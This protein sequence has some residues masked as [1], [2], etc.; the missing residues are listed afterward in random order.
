MP[1]SGEEAL[2][3]FSIGMPT[4][5]SSVGMTE[6]LM[7]GARPKHTP[8]SRHL[9]PNQKGYVSAKEIPSTTEHNVVSPISTGHIL[10]EG[11][12]IF[13]DMTETMLT[14]LD[15]QI[16][17]SG[18]AQKPKC[19]LMSN[20]LISGQVPSHSNAGESR[21]ISRSTDKIEDQYPDLYLPV[22]ENYKISGRFYG[23][24]DSVSMDNNPMIL[25]QLTGSTIYAVDRVR[26]QGN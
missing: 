21:A 2:V 18:E 10:G 8:N 23:Y 9:P 5:T 15:Q 16:A 14:T 26:L 12:D 11:A 25:M 3:T 17:L 24:M 19:S 13:T 22:A 1:K 20:T 7:V 6:N 4:M